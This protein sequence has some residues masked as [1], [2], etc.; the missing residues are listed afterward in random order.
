MKTLFDTSVIVAG[1][2]E[3]HPMHSRA[4]PWIK[5]AKDKIFELVIAA[6][7]IAESYAVLSSLP[8]KPR[9]SPLVARQLLS[10]NLESVGLIISLTPAEY[11]NTISRLAK[12]GLTGGIVYDALIAKTAQKT[13]VDRLVTLN[14][15]DFRRVWPEGE[16]VIVAP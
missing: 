4:F 9:I 12:I 7:T 6:H 3:A 8:M 10:E 16:G 13:R 2:I 15:E 11:L 14:L 5:Q 1:L